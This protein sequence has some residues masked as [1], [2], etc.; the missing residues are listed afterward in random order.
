M[1]KNKNGGR[2]AQQ[3]VS[4]LQNS[5]NGLSDMRSDTAPLIAKHILSK[6]DYHSWGLAGF[7]LSTHLTDKV[8]GRLAGM[9]K[10][11]MKQLE[12]IGRPI[13]DQAVLDAI[14]VGGKKDE[15]SDKRVNHSIF[16]AVAAREMLNGH[17]A[18]AGLIGGADTAMYGR[19]RYV[20]RKRD[21]AAT[22]GVNGDA[23]QLGKWKQALLVAAQVVAVS[24]LA[25]PKNSGEGLR[26]GRAVAAIG[27]LGGTAMSLYSGW[28][29]IRHLRNQNN[30]SQPE[31]ANHTA[32]ET[33]ETI[34]DLYPD[35]VVYAGQP[36]QLDAISPTIL[37]SLEAVKSPAVHSHAS[38]GSTPDAPD[39]I[40]QATQLLF[41]D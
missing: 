20:S 22:N 15:R 8:D 28:D 3:Q 34:A 12:A 18:Y 35:P 9:R 10:K 26:V 6:P 24:P 33:P 4:F 39:T 5:A 21:E 29:Q 1:P 30:Q 41:K 17:V 23:R 2:T 19:D 25:R 11:L 37:D 36:D 40:R 38:N 14:A 32:T 16:G 31:A 7:V 13:T 27:M